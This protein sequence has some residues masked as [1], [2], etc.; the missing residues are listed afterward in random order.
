MLL[1][2]RSR[3][4]ADYA[5]LSCRKLCAVPVCGACEQSFIELHVYDVSQ[6]LTNAR[7]AIR[8]ITVRDG[9]GC[10]LTVRG[11]LQV[12]QTGDLANMDGLQ[13]ELAAK[14]PTLLKIRN[15]LYSQRF[16]TFI[17]QVRALATMQDAC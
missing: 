2:G 4:S 3:S 9:V 16:R 12:F 17:E 1:C 7:K 8:G 5:Y 10:S 14:L 13:P 6:H 15:A 11:T